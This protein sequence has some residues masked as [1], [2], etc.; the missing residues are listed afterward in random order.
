M[1]R[2]QG[3]RPLA[4]DEEDDLGFG[5]TAD[6]LAEAL[7][8]GTSSDGLVI[9]VTGTWGSGKS[10]PINLNQAALRRRMLTNRLHVVEFKPWLVGD[11][12]APVARHVRRACGRHRPDRT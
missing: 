6:R 3:D 8:S 5:P 7:A 4:G 2:I 9:G 1:A 10:S 11:L 12:D